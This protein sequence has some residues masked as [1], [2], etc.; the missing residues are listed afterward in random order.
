[1][2]YTEKIRIYPNKLQ[3]KKIDFIL[4]ECKNLYNKLLEYHN[5]TY[6]ES[7]KSLSKFDYNNQIKYLVNLK[8]IEIHSQVLRTAS[9][10]LSDAFQRFFKKQNRYPKFKSIRQFKS[11]TYLQ[12]TGFAL[13]PTNKIR[14]GKFGK[15]KAKFT[16]EIN[17]T[18]KTCTI[19][20][21]NSGKYYAFIVIENEN[22]ISVSNRQNSIGIDLGIKNF[23]TT[24]EGMFI[25]RPKFIGKYKNK[26]I[27]AQRKLSRKKTGSHNRNKQRIKLAKIHEKIS[28]TRRDHHFKVAH[29]L[30][31]NYN[32]VCC[33]KLSSSF[34]ISKRKRKNKSIT[35]H[36][37][38]ISFYEFLTILNYMGLKY[39]SKIIEVDPFN[40]SQVCSNCGSIVSKSLETRIH[41]CPECNTILDRDVNAAINILNR[42]LNTRTVGTTGTTTLVEIKITGLN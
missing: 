35:K 39:S 6:K 16:R 23:I 21:M 7:K 22:N 30:V 9:T 37:I 31:N 20:K 12:S 26:L 29:Y 24:H 3:K 28:N 4:W 2:L 41:H 13:L 1:M 25:K 36:A 5:Q 18:L 14:L 32:I 8:E 17:G 11:F 33:E 42:G 34:M 27:R 19:K 40:T 10:R 15:V 38:D